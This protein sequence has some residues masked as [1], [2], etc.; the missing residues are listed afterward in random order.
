M[1]YFVGIFVNA[2]DSAP[3]RR[4]GTL[5]QQVKPVTIYVLK[6][7]IHVCTYF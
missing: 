6:H 3:E 5:E 7:T 2:L 1:M 4:Y